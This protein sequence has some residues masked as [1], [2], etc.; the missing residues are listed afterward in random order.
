MCCGF[1]KH[2]SL[3]LFLFKVGQVDPVPHPSVGYSRYSLSLSLFLSFFCSLCVYLSVCVVLGQRRLSLFPL[4][5]IHALL[6]LS[7]SFSL[8]LALSLSLSLS[9]SLFL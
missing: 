8:S 6:S 2:F 5:G 1:S 7:L 3:S 4:S 9:L